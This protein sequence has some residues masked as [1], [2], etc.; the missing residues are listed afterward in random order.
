M[1]RFSITL[2]GVVLAALAG[3][4]S[5]QAGGAYNASTMLGWQRETGAAAVAYGY[6]P[7]HAAPREAKRAH[8]GFAM[9]APVNGR[10]DRVVSRLQAPRFVDLKFSGAQSRDRWSATLNTGAATVWS[11]DPTVHHLLE[12]GMSWA[13]IGALTVAAGFGIFAILEDDIPPPVTSGGTGSGS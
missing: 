13:A 7:F 5:A 12:G 3:I 1:N 2:T 11:D 8:L 6:V 4:G 10:G 9:T